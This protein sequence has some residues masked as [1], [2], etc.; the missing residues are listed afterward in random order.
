[1][2]DLVRLGFLP[3]ELADDET[4]RNIVAPILGAVLEQ[5]SNGGEFRW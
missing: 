1:V 2:D 3:K 4:N 5:L